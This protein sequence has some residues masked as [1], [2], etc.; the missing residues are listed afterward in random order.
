MAQ[1]RGDITVNAEL[2]T[3]GVSETVT[4]TESPVAVQFNSSN[5]GLTVDSKLAADIPRNWNR[6]GPATI[7][8]HEEELVCGVLE[9]V[10]GGEDRLTVFGPV[11]WLN[12]EFARK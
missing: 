2:R 4:V 9:R 7:D 12:F 3:G 1:A 6:P 10:W 5:I 8:I 11:Q